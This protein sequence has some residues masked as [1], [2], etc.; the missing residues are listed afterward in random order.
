MRKTPKSQEPAAK[1]SVQGLPFSERSSGRK[2]K[3][4]GPSVP[5]RILSYHAHGK[6]YPPSCKRIKI[7]PPLPPSLA[8]CGLESNPQRIGFQDITEHL[9]PHTDVPL[10]I[11]EAKP[12]LQR[13]LLRTKLT[14]ISKLSSSHKKKK[15]IYGETSKVIMPRAGVKQ[16]T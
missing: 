9:F 15:K 10:N 12:N 14:R 3:I 1:K 11:D 5:R 6:R 16:S 2:K 13:P 8:R 4:P 7:S